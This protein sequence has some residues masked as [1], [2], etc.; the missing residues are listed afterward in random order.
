MEGAR[1]NGRVN[2]RYS[3][4]CRNRFAREVETNARRSMI[5]GCYS[6]NPSNTGS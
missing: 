2:D 1:A 6:E 5:D 3:D 4:V